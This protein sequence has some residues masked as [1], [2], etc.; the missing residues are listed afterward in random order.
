MNI[1][2]S[3]SLIARTLVVPKNL[4]IFSDKKMKTALGFSPV[5]TCKNDPLIGGNQR[6][7]LQCS[8]LWEE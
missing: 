5:K 3:K 1:I 8:S 6:G 2:A 4:S 7:T